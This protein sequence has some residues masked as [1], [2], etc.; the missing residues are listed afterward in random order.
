MGR[1]GGRERT[2]GGK[3]LR[4]YKREGKKEVGGGGAEGEMENGREEGEMEEGEM[5]EGEK[6]E[7]EKEEGRGRRGGRDGG[8]EGEM[9]EG[10]HKCRPPRDVY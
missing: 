10:I 5:E 8:E 1:D 4:N 7:G 2:R 3:C 9:E 6:E